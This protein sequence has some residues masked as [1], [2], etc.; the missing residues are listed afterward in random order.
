LA[1]ADT[2]LINDRKLAEDALRDRQAYA[3][4]V[5]QYK[6][7]LARYVKR[8]LGRQAQ[9][10]DDVLQDIFIK[11]YVNLNDY[12]RARPFSPWIYRIAHNETISYLRKRN[13]EPQTVAGEDAQL[14]LD[15]IA[16]NDDPSANWAE[17]RTAA[18]VQRALAQID[19][20]YRDVLV[21]RFLEDKSYDEIADILELPP[22]TVAT[23]IS[24]GLK[25]LKVPLQD[26]WD[27]TAMETGP[28][29]DRP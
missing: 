11:A 9:A 3:H 8:L 18:E 23:C 19:A 21:L 10:V 1:E 22:G 7:V 4:I 15:R 29:N 14:I 24:R 16:G 20:R 26:S 27:H 2:R 5:H 17:Q 25:Q 28:A 12:D 13:T 6:G